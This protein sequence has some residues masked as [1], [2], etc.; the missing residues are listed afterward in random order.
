[1][2]SQKVTWNSK[3]S[4]MTK[5]S[6]QNRSFCHPILMKKYRKRWA[7]PQ[8]ASIQKTIITFYKSFKWINVIL[9]RTN[10]NNSSNN[11]IQRPKNENRWPRVDSRRGN[12]S[13]L[14]T[15]FMETL[16]TKA[17]ITKKSC[18]TCTIITWAHCNRICKH[19]Q[20]K[21]LSFSCKMEMTLMVWTSWSKSIR[22][23]SKIISKIIQ[24]IK[25]GSHRRRF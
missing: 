1:M 23:L 8:P 20:S 17:R 25:I 10:S 7:S 16:W 12:S 9:F 14:T 24:W 4:R 21:C 22:I 11:E 2:H 18:H 15:V 13:L 6:T 3:K 5:I 19:K